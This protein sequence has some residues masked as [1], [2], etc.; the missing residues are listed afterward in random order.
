MRVKQ[1]SEKISNYEEMIM[2]KKHKNDEGVK[3]GGHLKFYIQW[4]LYMAA[5]LV[6]ISVGCLVADIKSG[7][8]MLVLSMVFAIMAGVF[9]FFNRS[10]VLK[11]LMEIATEYGE[12]QNTV[13]KELRV[14]YAILQE[15]GKIIWMNDQFEEVLQKNNSGDLYIQKFIPTL[16]KDNFPKEAMQYKKTN[17]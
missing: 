17:Y 2:E 9:Y 3:L 12:A 13:L 15:D 5:I 6:I 10:I 14:P 1:G 7:A 16:V 8:I 11:D 4:P